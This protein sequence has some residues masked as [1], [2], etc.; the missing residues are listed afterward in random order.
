M[1][2]NPGASFSW[3]RSE[4]SDIDRINLRDGSFSKPG[5]LPALI[6]TEVYETVPLS[7]PDEGYLLRFRNER[8]AGRMDMKL[9]LSFR[10][11]AG[12]WS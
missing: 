1:I 3:R 11:Q 12:G 7:R 4:A 9:M 2:W 5:K 6:N 10:D 8:P